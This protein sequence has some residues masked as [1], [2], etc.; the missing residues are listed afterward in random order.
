MRTE[1]M[2][3]GQKPR[4]KRLRSELRQQDLRKH[5]DWRILVHDGVWHGLDVRPLQT[6][7]QD[8]EE[9][10]EEDDDDDDED[11]EEQ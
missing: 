1:G 5:C 8:N 9:E 11:E 2:A 10:E 4:S 6:Q 7:Q 3:P